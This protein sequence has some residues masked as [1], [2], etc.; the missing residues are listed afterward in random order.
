M[1][2]I[3]QERDDMKKPSAGAPDPKTVNDVLVPVDVPDD[4]GPKVE[5]IPADEEFAYWLNRYMDR[6]QDGINF[7][8]FQTEADAIDAIRWALEDDEPIPEPPPGIV[9]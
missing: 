1:Y 3:D 9:I 6:F 8:A 7:D 2:D 5:A 4:M